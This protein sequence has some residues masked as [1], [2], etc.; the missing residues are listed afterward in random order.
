MGKR[1]DALLRV[2]TLLYQATVGYL[3][4][5]VIGVIALVWMVVDVI[6]QLIFGSDGLSSS[7]MLAMQVSDSFEW[8]AGQTVYAVTGGGDGE[9]RWFWTM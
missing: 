2:W 1:R 5:L 3:A 4:A 7:S 9:F 6:W 8:A